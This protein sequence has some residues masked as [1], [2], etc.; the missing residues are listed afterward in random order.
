MQYLLSEARIILLSS[1]TSMLYAV[2][3]AV[4]DLLFPLKWAGVL[5]PVLPARLIQ[6]LHAPTPYL[7]GIEKR[8]EKTEL[9]DDDFVLVDLDSD[10]IESTAQ[11]IP[12]PR[13]QRRKLMSL[14]QLAAPL[15]YK[16]GVKPGPP[17]YIVETYP[18]DAFSSESPS[19]FSASTPSTQLAKFVN[20]NSTS[21]GPNASP[22]SQPRP[23]LFNAFSNMRSG[24]SQGNERPRTSSASKHSG[25]SQSSP[26]SGTFPPL[27][28]TPVS[29]NDSGFALQASLREKRSGYFDD[30]SRR[31]ASFGTQEARRR[32]SIPFLGHST[33][34]SVSNLSSD[35]PSS[36][37]APST[38]GHC[39]L[40]ASTIMPQVLMQPVRNTDTTSWVEG[41]CFQWQS[42][43]DRSSCSICEER[44]EDGMF[45]CTGCG[46][47]VHS[48]CAEQI[49]LP[50]PVAF[51]PE[52]VRAAFVRCFASLFYTY[53]KY[54]GPPSAEQRRSG[55]VYSFKMNDFMR[56]LPH[57]NADYMAMLQQT[58]GISLSIVSAC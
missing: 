29:R 8:Y 45:K 56:S 33:N 57:E 30:K 22:E 24:K 26:V 1:H 19:I 54:M 40:A 28:V 52:Q 25:S 14:L 53:R 48:R 51:Y 23:P 27:P 15:H 3:R 39:T 44:A 16:F 36:G 4:L 21:F 47:M 18:F 41:H 7:I 58:Q 11:P 6:A 31:S 35:L 55:F 13:Q 32:P 43:D 17:L 2:T 50:C 37:Y 20:L 34:L 9:P 46:A 38:Y 49:S 12:L 10:M 5:I 42:R